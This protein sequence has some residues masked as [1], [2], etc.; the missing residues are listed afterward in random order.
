MTTIEKMSSNLTALLPSVKKFLDREPALLIDGRW[1]PARSGETFVSLN[2]A[3]GL[4]LASIASGDAADVDLAVKAARRALGSGPWSRIKPQDRAQM[5]WRL[6]DLIM[7]HADELAQLETL[8]QGK[9]LR[10]SRDG[11][12]PGSA[13]TFRYMAGWATKLTGNTIQVG[14]PGEFHS[15]TQREPVGV[16]GQIVPWNFPLAMAAWKLAPALA[17][18]CTVVL[19]PAEN[20]PLTT[21]RLGELIQEA[22]FP[23]GVVNIVTGF[24]ATAGAAIAEHP[25]ID[26]VAFTG[27]TDVGK[28]VVR[29]ATGNLKRVSLELGGKNP[30][31]V[32]EDADLAA[33][34]PGLIQGS[35][36]NSGQV[37]TAP[38]RVFVHASVFEDVVAGLSEGAQALKVGPGLA[39]DSQM[40][41]VISERQ[42][43]SITGHID[44]GVAAGANITAGGGRLGTEGYFVAPTVV[45]NVSQHMLIA[46]EE[47]FGPVVVLSPFGEIEDV[48]RMANDTQYGLTAQVW[49]QNVSQAHRMAARLSAGSIWVNGK[50]M[51]IALPFGGF[52]QSGWGQE[53][54]AEGV[55]MYTRSKTV[56]V[57]L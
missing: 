53:K 7:E 24:G 57:A 17:A 25:D 28:S 9:P 50:S 43:V 18:G 30:S 46:R 27:S 42:L 4:T 54:G 34:I 52:K 15:Y 10:A 39:S 40:G 41:P 37:C 35:F 48:L 5:L 33:A 51:D 13:E 22:G 1:V 2:P 49:T 19:K 11:D 16:V 38:S 23:D 6:S 44:G 12:I 3:D 31:I 21:L 14:A 47:I 8:D 20:T 36:A 32:M 56:V 45:T 55:E 26:K 29:A